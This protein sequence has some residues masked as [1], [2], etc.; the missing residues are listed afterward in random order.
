MFAKNQE[1]KLKAVT[2]IGVH[3][4]A[5]SKMIYEIFEKIFSWLNFRRPMIHGLNNFYEEEQG[6]ENI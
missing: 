4:T 5:E 2:D 1:V 6:F 3:D